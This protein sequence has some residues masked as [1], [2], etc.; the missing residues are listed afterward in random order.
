MSAKTSASVLTLPQSL[1]QG[2]QEQLIGLM[3]TQMR[4]AGALDTL[5][6]R[7]CRSDLGPQYSMGSQCDKGWPVSW[8]GQL[9]LARDMDGA[10]TGLY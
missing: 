8:K 1:A 7:E 3:V 2:C 10:Q 9:M 6:R 4:L 5:Q